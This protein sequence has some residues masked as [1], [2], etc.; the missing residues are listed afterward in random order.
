MEPHVLDCATIQKN[1]VTRMIVD[2][3]EIEQC[4]KTLVESVPEDSDRHGLKDTP[5]RAAEAFQ[6]LTQG[7][8]EDVWDIV[9]GALFDSDNEGMVIVRDIELYSLC[10]HHILPFFGKCHVGYIP[11]G[12]VLGV[13]KFARI[14][15][16]FARR[17]QT[18]EKMAVQVADAIVEVTKSTGVGV[19]IESKHT[20]MTMRGV[21]KPNAS[22]VTS[23]MIG[24]MKECPEKSRE[25]L[26]FLS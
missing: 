21:A 2:L 8:R 14:V 1:L 6:Y 17:L 24:K 7:Y 20:C 26:Q 3:K 16:M 22:M 15:D 13:S 19:V 10:E 18:Q 4:Y 5:R 25:F 12:K 9:N 11:N 23:L